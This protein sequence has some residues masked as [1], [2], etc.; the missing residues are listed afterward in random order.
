M[1]ILVLKKLDHK[2]RNYMEIKKE[3]L[4]EFEAD[5]QSPLATVISPKSVAL[6]RVAIVT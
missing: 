2:L 4:I 5:A 3:Y 1:R 6:P